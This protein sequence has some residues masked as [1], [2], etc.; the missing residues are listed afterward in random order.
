MLE[1]AFNLEGMRPQIAFEGQSVRTILSLV[2][3]G[4]E[5]AVIPS[6][7]VRVQPTL[8][9]MSLGQPIQMK[10]TLIWSHAIAATP[11]LAEFQAQVT[12]NRG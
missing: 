1:A 5:W 3:A 2:A 9:V 10:L 11:M 8:R 12:A 7:A 6:S 4:M